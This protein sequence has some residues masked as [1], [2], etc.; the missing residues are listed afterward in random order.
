MQAAFVLEG[1]K[2]GSSREKKRSKGAG[3]FM[4]VFGIALSYL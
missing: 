4:G 2:R 1:R 3:M